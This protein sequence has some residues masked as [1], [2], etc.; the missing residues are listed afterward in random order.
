MSEGNRNINSNEDEVMESV[1]DDEKAWTIDRERR[2]YGLRVV[3]PKRTYVLPWGQFLYAEGA[4]DTVRA[5]FSMHDVVVTGCGLDALLADFA[6]QVV[7]VLQ[8]PPRAENFLPAPGPRVVAVEV[9][10]AEV[11]GPH[12][13]L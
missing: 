12:V 9:R 1:A 8:H 10:R 11:S 13:R 3:L 5:V 7:T 6:A 4:P 2:A